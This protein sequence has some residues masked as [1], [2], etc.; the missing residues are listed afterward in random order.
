MTDGEKRITDILTNE[1][2]PKFL[3]VKDIS[4]EKYIACLIEYSD[5]HMN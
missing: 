5:V 2:E 3:E 1:L 4:G